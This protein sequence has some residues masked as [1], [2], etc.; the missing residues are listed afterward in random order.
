[1][2][3]A[4]TRGR[5]NIYSPAIIQSYSDLTL[6]TIYVR[7]AQRMY[8]YNT[9]TPHLTSKSNNLKSSIISNLV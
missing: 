1:M 7:T 8:E 3:F 4:Y 9:N 6:L 2:V 5:F